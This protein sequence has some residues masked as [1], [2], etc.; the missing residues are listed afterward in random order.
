MN[1]YQNLVYGAIS[2]FDNK[3]IQIWGRPKIM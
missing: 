3:L 2:L 1:A